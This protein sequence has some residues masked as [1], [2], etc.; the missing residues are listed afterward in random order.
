MKKALLQIYRLD[1]GLLVRVLRW[2]VFFVLIEGVTLA[3]LRQFFMEAQAAFVATQ[4]AETDAVAKAIGIWSNPI[5]LV[6]ALLVWLTFR[7]F[8][9]SYLS[10]RMLRE[11]SVTQSRI[12]SKLFDNYIFSPI[13]G[14]TEDSISKQNQTLFVASSAFYFQL[15]LPGAKILNELVVA[16]AVVSVILVLAPAATLLIGVVLVSV[17]VIYFLVLGRVLNRVGGS[18]WT[19]LDGMRQLSEDSLSDLVSIR[20][21]AAE[22][23]LSR[24]FGAEALDFCNALAMDRTLAEAPRYLVEIALVLVTV[25]VVT[26]GVGGG[27]PTEGLSLFAAA[28]IRL[29]P[30]MQRIIAIRHNL[31]VYAPDVTDIVEDLAKLP[32]G[33]ADPGAVKTRAPFDNS[34]TISK[35]EFR[36]DPA[37]P[38][39]LNVPDFRLKPG[40]WVL[41]QGESGSGKS[42]LL[43]LMLGLV[44]PDKGDIRIDGQGGDLLNRLRASSVAMVSQT[45]FLLHGTVLENIS[46]PLREVS[47]ADAR[48]LIHDL[49]LDKTPDFP[50]GQSGSKL[51]GGQRQKVAVIRALIQ[52]PKLLILDEAWSQLDRSNML[53][54]LDTI[55]ARLPDSTVVV[56][57]HTE[58]PA[59]YF[60]RFYLVADRTVTAQPVS[61][62]T[63][64]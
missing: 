35:A 21:H 60:D 18:R 31:V 38:V 48:Q 4:T 27:A 15:L 52:N 59:S 26:V 20:I 22:S 53:N 56:V 58:L 50:V 29:V 57:S 23:E 2:T 13:E 24:R 54:M 11:I 47:E 6:V 41:I 28:A 36:R 62:A 3:L 16:I 61:A 33:P 7:M 40:E 51:S 45:P 25:I 10:L 30:A 46:F 12:L 9:S 63:P 17:Y 8:A 32:V 42:T 37:G 43:K 49:R 19:A 5:I 34:L 55:R 39:D 44:E 1:P 14:R 64:A